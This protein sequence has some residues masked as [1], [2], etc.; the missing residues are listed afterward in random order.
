MLSGM[1][2]TFWP[3]NVRSSLIITYPAAI[4]RNF[5]EI[6]RVLDGLFLVDEHK[7]ATPCNWKKGD[8]CALHFLFISRM[9]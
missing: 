1:L 7:V 5:D 4:G 3:Y 9:S 6:F 8:V 2:F